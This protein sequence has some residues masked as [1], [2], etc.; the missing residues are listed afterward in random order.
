MHV[1]CEQMEQGA[2]SSRVGWLLDAAHRRASWVGAAR[3]S[4]GYVVE[5]GEPLLFDLIAALP[6]VADVD[7]R[8]A[9]RLVLHGGH[10]L[11]PP[12]TAGRL[13]S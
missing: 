8:L 6:V 2:T 11:R 7:G 5:L 13:L 10:L 3:R 12:A 4:C 9:V 1:L